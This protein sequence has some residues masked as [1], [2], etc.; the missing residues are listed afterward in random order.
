V[1]VD[2]DRVE[3][4][5]VAW[6]RSAEGEN[7]L[8][9]GSQQLGAAVRAD[10]HRQVDGIQPAGRPKLRAERVL[11]QRVDQITSHEVTEIVRTDASAAGERM[12]RM[13]H[14]AAAD[15]EDEE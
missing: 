9:A 6:I 10:R 14:R 5:R 2:H 4:T 1:I 13:V 7:A 15:P 3:V 12:H 11:Q 8:Q